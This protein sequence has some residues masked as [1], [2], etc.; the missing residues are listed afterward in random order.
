VPEKTFPAW[1]LPVLS[2]ILNGIILIVILMKTKPT[3]SLNVLVTWS[4]LTI[5]SSFGF[6][7][8]GKMLN[9]DID[10]SHLLTETGGGASFSRFQFLIFTFVIS[11]SLFLVTAH[12]Y[13]FPDHIPAEILT[14]LG[15][16]AS[17]YA[18]S[19]GI[20]ATDPAGMAKIKDGAADKNKPGN[21]PQGG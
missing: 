13:K 6:I 15:I 21:Q 14:L 1:V 17:T 3:D 12:A 20:Q 7:V 10:L 19:K 11:L 9:D 5:V 18:V 4:V 8:L 2:L 16:S